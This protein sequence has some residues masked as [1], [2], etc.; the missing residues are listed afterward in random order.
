MNTTAE[1]M[2]QLWSQTR[3]AANAG[4][5]ML[6][7]DLQKAISTA[8]GL[9]WYDLEPYAKLL[10]PVITPLRNEI[11]RVPG[12]GDTAT[13][14]KTI[15]G[16]NI[17]NL[18][19]G[20]SEGQ[21]GGSVTTKTNDMVAQ[22]KSFG[23]DDSVTFEAD[24]AA[25]NFDDVKQLAVDNLL[26]AV[27]IQEEQCIVGGNASLALGVTPTPAVSDVATTGTLLANT[28]YSVIC[29]ALTLEGFVNSQP[30]GPVPAQ[31][32]RTNTD[33]SQSTY[34]GGSAQK[35][36]N[37]T[38]TTANDGNNT[39]CVAASVSPVNGAVGY[40]WYWGAAGAEVLGQITTIN[41][42]LIKANATGTQTALSLPASDNSQNGLI[43]DGLMTQ[44]LTPG[45]GAY[46]KVM[47]TGTAGT[48]TTLT[49]DGAGGIVEIDAAF[50]SFWD[51]ARLSPQAML[52]NSQ[53]LTTITKNAIAGGTAPI[54][55][56]VGDMQGA[57]SVDQLKLT[58]GAVVGTY[59]NKYTMN[60]G[61]LVQVLLHPN[62]PPG[63][64]IF[65][66]RTIPYPLSNVKNL[67]QM[68]MQR[69]YFQIEWPQVRPAWEYSV[70][71]RGLLQNY[72]L[73]AFGIITNI[74]PA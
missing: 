63:T 73:P 27:M 5:A 48:G 6:P 49:G 67:L 38:V 18:S 70:W 7:P 30:L 41:S 59:L 50:K 4:L 22:Y 26:R 12:S 17:K 44:I 57:T 35:S 43:F 45:S 72:F 74:A 53:E 62:I 58:A 69:D 19:F 10:Y 51:T 16:V 1:T 8:T 2:A 65:Y 33:G 36:A 28:T 47:A 42:I 11:K 71:A 64:I 15:T 24:L 13:H 46:V 68:K 21:R 60:G 31:V 55:R 54:F 9:T 56:F 25:Q 52:V 34:G 3:K 61:Q 37:N 23:L 29:V 20:L 14:W 32:T 40:A 39:H 66:S